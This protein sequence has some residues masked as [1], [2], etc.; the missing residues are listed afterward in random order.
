MLNGPE[1]YIGPGCERLESRLD[2]QIYSP[3]TALF[4][5]SDGQ[6]DQVRG[7]LVVDAAEP[8]RAAHLPYLQTVQHYLVC[9]TEQECSDLEVGASE[10]LPKDVLQA[11]GTEVGDCPGHRHAGA[12]TVWYTGSVLGRQVVSSQSRSLQCRLEYSPSLYSVSEYT[13]YST[14]LLRELSARTGNLS[15]KYNMIFYSL[16]FLLLFTG[17]FQ[18]LSQPGFPNVIGFHKHVS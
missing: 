10:G 14:Y 7:E 12:G 8:G 9:P 17:Q 18:T 15:W 13:A 2:H 6:L 3:C 5:Q 16:S 11:G 4:L 1:N